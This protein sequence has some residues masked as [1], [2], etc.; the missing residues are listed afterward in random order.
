MYRRKHNINSAQHYPWFQASTVGLGKY[1]SQIV[2]RGGKLL[3]HTH[4]HTHTEAI[5]KIIQGDSYKH[6]WLQEFGRIENYHTYSSWEALGKKVEF[7]FSLR[8]YKT[9]IVKRSF[10]ALAKE[11][12]LGSVLFTFGHQV[13][14]KKTGFLHSYLEFG[15]STYL[16]SLIFF[17]FKLKGWYSG[18]FQLIQR[19]KL[20]NGVQ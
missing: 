8:M 2:G 5:I 17:T 14:F 19:Q 18:S 1:P 12:S 16:F 15:K 20:T 9:D 4:T 7:E 11:P 10:F 6:H 13:K 3:L